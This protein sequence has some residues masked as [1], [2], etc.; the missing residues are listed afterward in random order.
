[1]PPA[2]PRRHTLSSYDDD[3]SL[4]YFSS[5]LEST[6]S[7]VRCFSGSEAKFQC[8]LHLQ[9]PSPA[10]KEPPVIFWKDGFG[11]LLR[12]EGRTV[13]QFDSSTGLC[14]LSIGQSRLSDC[15][16]YTCTAVTEGGSAS[17]TGTLQV[18]PLPPKRPKKA[19]VVS[20]LNS[21]RLR[22]EWESEEEEIPG[23]NSSGGSLVKFFTVEHSLGGG[24]SE[25]EESS[26]T[27]TVVVDGTEA[28]I[29]HL[30]PGQMYA[31]R[32]IAHGEGRTRSEPSPSTEPVIIPHE[33]EEELLLS[34][35]GSSSPA[36]VS[37]P[38]ESFQKK[39]V[40]LEDL[41]R[42]R[43]SVVRKVQE[44]SSGEERAAKVVPRKRWKRQLVL[45]EFQVL[46]AIRSQ[47]VPA[48]V[49]FCE[50]GR[51]GSSIVV[52][53]LVRGK[54]ILQYFLDKGEEEE[55]CYGEGEVMGLMEQLLKALEH[56]HGL[57]IAHLDLE[58]RIGRSNF[59]SL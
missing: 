38:E 26:W 53:E 45:K 24:G 14:S 59:D 31:F 15:G 51:S 47:F 1:V 11:H 44:A 19:P 36:S 6:S 20:S 56:L 37:V 57:E 21:E 5:S 4:P 32:I 23:E 12:N 30:I 39:W 33:E 2:S 9:Q 54:E 41:G 18:T 7:P 28:E 27:S 46:Q 13:I 34:P 16:R 43:F 48:A 22:L 10:V 17:T 8:I 50:S 25:E 58:V 29:R 49:E 42:G 3:E 40:E 35:G 55:G 52:M